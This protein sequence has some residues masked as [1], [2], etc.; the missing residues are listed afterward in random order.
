MPDLGRTS[1]IPCRIRHFRFE[2]ISL[3]LHHFVKETYLGK[4]TKAFMYLP[5]GNRTTDERSPWGG[6]NFTPQV[7]RDGLNKKPDELHL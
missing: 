4:V 1:R 6:G 7:T 2:I 5:T 3:V